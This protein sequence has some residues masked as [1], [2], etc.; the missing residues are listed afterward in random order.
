ML[1]HASLP[2]PSASALAA[3]QWPGRKNLQ[4]HYESD[5][6]AMR[7]FLVRCDNDQDKARA[8]LLARDNWLWCPKYGVTSVAEANAQTA[9]M[10]EQRRTSNLPSAGASSKFARLH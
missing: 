1:T 8:A 9:G 10:A 2:P 5:V 6:D 7:R 3:V 4:K